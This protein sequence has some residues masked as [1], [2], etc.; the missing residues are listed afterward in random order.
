MLIILV[1]ELAGLGRIA[2]D[3]LEVLQHSRLRGAVRQVARPPRLNSAGQSSELPRERC[4]DL[5]RQS[6]AGGR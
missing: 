6:R 5:F 2:W 4:F 1:S 3:F